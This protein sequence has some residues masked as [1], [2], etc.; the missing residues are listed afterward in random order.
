[1]SIA[2]VIAARG[3]A[4]VLHFT[5]NRGL[6]GMLA[7]GEVRS[8]K[9][10][11]SD[12]YLKSI[13]HKNAIVRPEAAENFDKKEDWLDFVNLSISA[14]NTSYMGFSR[15]WPH[16]Q[17]IWWYIMSFD[18]AIMTHEGV[19][20]TTTNNAYEHCRREAEEEGLSALFSPSV[21]RKGN[22]SARRGSRANHLPTCQQA[23]V[24]YPHSLSLDYLRHIYVQSPEDSDRARGWLRDF[25]PPG[26]EVSLREDVFRGHPN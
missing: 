5:T 8:R 18:P 11:N 21:R 7:T 9:L 6:V 13:L 24:L 1:M 22:W 4:E 3:I 19:Y 15:R 17:K 14:I 25:G 10:L 12:D 16:N 2:D 26:V 23:E 20:F